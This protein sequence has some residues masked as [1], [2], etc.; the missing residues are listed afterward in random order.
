VQQDLGFKTSA[1]LSIGNYEAAMAGYPVEQFIQEASM[2]PPIPQTAQKALAIIRDGE[3]NAADLA[4]ILASDQVLAARVLRWAN[5]AYYGMENRI[6]TVRQA[7][8]IL[9]MNVLQE[10]VMASSV[11]DQMNQPLPGYGL[12]RGE[13]WHH[14]LGTA[15]GAQLIS[16]QYRLKIDQEA[17]YAGLLCDIGKLIFEKHLREINWDKSDWDRQSFLEMERVCFGFDH[18]M[19]GAELAHHWQ[20]PEE[21]VT[22]IAFHHEPQQAPRHQEL[23]AAV[24]IADISMK[25]LGI[26]IGVDGLRY[27]LDH[28][29]LKALNMSWDDLF[30]LSALV[31]E[32]LARA[33]D[34]IDIN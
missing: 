25:V 24:H 19:L 2:L 9:G 3:T 32:Q 27:P 30:S 13:L 26:G 8:M 17:Y 6:V 15:V 18:A 31:R 28:E 29:A 20:L 23:V 21:L 34:L 4:D 14:A 12:K 22:A 5:S 16:K 33:R 7:I 11:S 10:L 1:S